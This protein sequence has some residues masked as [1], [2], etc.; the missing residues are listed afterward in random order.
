MPVCSSTTFYQRARESFG[1]GSPRKGAALSR[2][3]CELW[4]AHWS[5]SVLSIFGVWLGHQ[6]VGY[7]KIVRIIKFESSI[8]SLNSERFSFFLLYTSDHWWSLSQTLSQAASSAEFDKEVPTDRHGKTAR[9][10]RKRCSSFTRLDCAHHVHNAVSLQHH[11][12]DA[13]SES[14]LTGHTQGASFYQFTIT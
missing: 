6:F 12:A 4:S 5:L 7:Q 8:R 9:E 3:V 11:F 13:R 14:F 10:F 1:R 2:F